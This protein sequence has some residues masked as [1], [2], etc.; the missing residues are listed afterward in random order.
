[1]AYLKIFKNEMGAACGTYGRQERYMQGFGGKT[2]GNETTWKSKTYKGG[3]YVKGS[4]RSGMRRH[5]PD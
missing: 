1:V 4:S 5:G 2:R 3:Q